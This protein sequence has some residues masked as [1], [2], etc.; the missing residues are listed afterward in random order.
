MRS[1]IQLCSF[2]QLIGLRALAPQ[3]IQV[4]KVQKQ[5]EISQEK[6][7]TATISCNQTKITERLQLSVK[8]YLSQHH[9]VRP[10]LWMG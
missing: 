8:L 6:L 10:V 5:R 3:H 1:E 9:S 7:R 2:I 4:A